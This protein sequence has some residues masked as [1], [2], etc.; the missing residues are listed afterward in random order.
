MGE[1]F[2]E[3]TDRLGM[4][5]YGARG[6]YIGLAAVKTAEA[7][8]IRNEAEA[9][10]PAWPRWGTTD[11]WAL[12][13]LMHFMHDLDDSEGKLYLYGRYTSYPDDYERTS[14]STH[15][16]RFRFALPFTEGERHALTT[17]VLGV[18][19]PR[20]G[21]QS[22]DNRIRPVAALDVYEA[23]RHRTIP[24]NHLLERFWAWRRDAREFEDTGSCDIAIEALQGMGKVLLAYMPRSIS[25]HMLHSA[26]LDAIAASRRSA[27]A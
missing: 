9:R 19:E 14:Y 21:W 16:R 23:G 4:S 26:E 8:V 25:D 13:S 3:L 7:L 6:R 24:G 22:M 5:P 20:S 15:V 11:K 1:A 18:M 27:E 17:K 2:P 10:S 12:G